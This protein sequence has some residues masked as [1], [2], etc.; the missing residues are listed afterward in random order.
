MV[1]VTAYLFNQNTFSWDVESWEKGREYAKR[2][3]TEG[4]WIAEDE[5][6]VFYPVHQVYKVKL[7]E[8]D[9]V[10]PD[11]YKWHTS[12]YQTGINLYSEGP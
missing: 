10:V 2:I 9:E 8:T 1:R 4:L 7:Q 3:V 6:E 11:N 5:E 12:D